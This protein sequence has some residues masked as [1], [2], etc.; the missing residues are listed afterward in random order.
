MR[1]YEILFSNVRG[2]TRTTPVLNEI[3]HKRNGIEPQ[4]RFG[5]NSKI[6]KLIKKETILILKYYETSES[7][8]LSKADL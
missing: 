7:K 2:I 3:I 6:I 5:L 8:Q 4:I 1:V